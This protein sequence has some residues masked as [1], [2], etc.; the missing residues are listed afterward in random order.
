MGTQK[1]MDCVDCHGTMEN[2]AKNP[3]PWLNEPRCD[4]AS[5]HGNGYAQD[6]PLYRQSK[7]HGA[8]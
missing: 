4:A 7:G 1:A 2:I 8:L 3:S 5:C 6:M